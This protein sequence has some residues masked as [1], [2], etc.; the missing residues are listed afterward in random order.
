MQLCYMR[1]SSNTRWLRKITKTR[2]SRVICMHQTKT[3]RSG[4]EHVHNRGHTNCC[5]VAHFHSQDR[6]KG[7][8][9][10]HSRTPRRQKCNSVAHC[11]LSDQEIWFTV[12]LF[13]IRQ[14]RTC[15]RVALFHTQARKKRCSVGRCQA[16]Q[17]PSLSSIPKAGSALRC[18]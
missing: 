16:L 1:D 9:V 5:S 3:K 15:C 6:K 11:L 2:C 7:C 4:V 8:S 18:D 10:C 14:S 12:R 13:L 17:C